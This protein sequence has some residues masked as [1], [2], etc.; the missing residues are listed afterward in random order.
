MRALPVKSV[1]LQHDFTI[2]GNEERHASKLGNR[3]VPYGISFI[4][5]PD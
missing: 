4:L 2:Y 3:A 5:N 1:G